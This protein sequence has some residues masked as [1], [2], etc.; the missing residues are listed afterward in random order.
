MTNKLLVVNDTY[1]PKVD[2]VLIFVEE[3]IK[4]AQNDFEITLLV[5]DYSRKKK[6]KKVKTV[7]LEL[8]KRF[9]AFTY[10][11]IKYSRSNRKN[12]KKAVKDSS[13]VFIQVFGPIGVLAFRYA[14]KMKKK[15]VVY[16]H[17]TPWE[18]LE[19]HY[20]LRKITAKLTKKYFISMYNKADIL[21]VPFHEFIGELRKAGIKNKMEVA[22]LGV[23]IDRF[24]PAKDKLQM[25]KKLKIPLKKIITYV[26]RVSNEKNTLLLLDAFQ[27]LKGEVHLLIVGD[28]QPELVK[29]FREQNDC[30]VTGFV[31]NVEDYLKASDIF[32]MPSLTETT[33]L[34]TLEAMSTGLPVLATKVGF[35]KKYIIK[36]HNGSFFPRNSSAHLAL[37][38]EKLLQNPELA[39]KYGNNARKTV[40]YAFSW[41]RS[42]NKIKRIL[43]RF[44]QN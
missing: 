3:F 21:L 31:S 8:S 23:D 30:T 39:Q 13:V 44:D 19:K 9:S 20:S 10:Q 37:K 27:K 42:I 34:A 29:Q 7:F 40:A 35:V 33:S 11:P 12:I 5:P 24:S 14:R 1:Y 18:F 17:N 36:D 28:G 22:R 6:F 43:R 2:G 26:G 4:R 25:K 32:V 16:V 41:E 15:I 38:I